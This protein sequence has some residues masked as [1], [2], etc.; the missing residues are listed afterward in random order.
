MSNSNATI[1]A[2]SQLRAEY[3]YNNYLRLLRQMGQQ[4]TVTYDI[5]GLVEAQRAMQVARLVDKHTVGDKIDFSGYL[6]EAKEANPETEWCDFD[7]YN[8]KSPAQ[9]I[10]GMHPIFLLAHHARG[11]DAG[12]G[13]IVDIPTRGDCMQIPVI[14]E[15]GPEAGEIYFISTAFNK[16]D[17][18]IYFTYFPK[19]KLKTK[20]KLYEL[21]DS[22]E[23]R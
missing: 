12:E 22:Y 9:G 1:A 18:R 11:H 19:R 2:M 13:Q 10:I 23:T 15:G 7:L 6:K 3:D 8:T 16:G 17:T 20:Y 14:T 4:K 21:L 5:D